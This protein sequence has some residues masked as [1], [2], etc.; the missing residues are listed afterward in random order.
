MFVP[1]IC[2][3][4][5]LWATVKTG[6]SVIV[7]PLW[8]QCFLS[9]EG[10]QTVS[11]TGLESVSPII[12]NAT[13]RRRVRKFELLSTHEKQLNVEMLTDM[14]VAS[15]HAWIFPLTCIKEG[16]KPRWS[17]I[18][19]YSSVLLSQ[20][21]LAWENWKLHKTPINCRVILQCAG[22]PIEKQYSTSDLY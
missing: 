7:L 9:S 20:R 6:L 17:Q 5:Y 21:V 22:I 14:H 12:L 3:S 16:S 11:T 15:T 2:F 19:R 4:T 8:N 10:S 1:V 13:E 18:I